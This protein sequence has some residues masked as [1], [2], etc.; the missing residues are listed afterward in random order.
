MAFEQKK[1]ALPKGKSGVVTIELPKSGDEGADSSMIS[2]YENIGYQHV[3][4]KGT[5]TLVMECPKS[6]SEKREADA[7]ALHYQRANRIENPIL[8]DG[9]RIVSNTVERLAPVS[10]D[11]LLSAVG[12]TEDEEPD[13]D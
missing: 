13:L 2:H 6:V 1:S 3:S 5:G 4:T 7:I 11:S 9:S 12:V 10:A 8:G